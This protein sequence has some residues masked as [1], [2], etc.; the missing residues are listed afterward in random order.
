MTYDAQVVTDV[1]GAMIDLRDALG[2]LTGWTVEVDNIGNSLED[3]DDIIVS[4]PNNAP[5][6]GNPESIRIIYDLQGHHFEIQLG[7]WDGASFNN[8]GQNNPSGRITSDGSNLPGTDTVEYWLQRKAGD[9]FVFF[10]RR[11]EDDG[12][13]ASLWMSYSI[14]DKIWAYDTANFTESHGGIFLSNSSDASNNN[15]DNWIMFNTQN[16]WRNPRGMLNP[17]QN[18][19]N[20]LVRESL[21]LTDTVQ[22][23]AGQKPWIGKQRLFAQER[24]G[25]DVQSQDTILDGTD[26]VYEILKFNDPR[27]HLLIR[28]D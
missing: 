1:E 21:H 12:V 19:D 27:T 11:T 6:T 20:Y 10:I 23:D 9:G 24:S 25:T 14:L 17:D 16:S 13:N 15:A 28:A 7:E 8:R 26:T 18:F 3:Q 4:T 22:T 5:D 2:A